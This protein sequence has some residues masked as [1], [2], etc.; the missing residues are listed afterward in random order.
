MFQKELGADHLSTGKAWFALAQ[1]SFNAG[2][3]PKARTQIANALRIERRV[4]DADNPILGDTLSMQGQIY[5]GLGQLPE[6]E[7]SLSEAVAIYRK[8]FDGPHYLIGIAE[9]YLG[10]IES[11]RGATTAAL[12]TLDDAKLNYDASY[13]K[14]HPNHGDLLVNRAKVLARAGRMGEARSDCA[15]G[16]AI[17]RETLGADASFT[18]Q[19][20]A[21]CAAIVPAKPT[22]VARG[23]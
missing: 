11:Q 21:E 8:A 9:V 18:K 20:T 6:A 14:T 10:L 22:R 19:M 2:D 13:G 16:L 1:N 15:A 5:Q 7:R 3:L 17:L 23:A 12:A 4:L